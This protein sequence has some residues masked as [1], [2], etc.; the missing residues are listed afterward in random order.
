MVRIQNVDWEVGIKEVAD[1]SVDLLLTDPP[2]GMEYQSNRRKEKHK[3]IQNDNNLDWLVGW[4]DELKRVMKDE[5]H[6]YIFCSW[7]NVEVFKYIVG[8]QFNVKNILIWE[9]NN[10][11]SGDLLG[12]YAPKYEMV[13]FC[14]NGQKKLKGGRDSN[15]LKADKTAND[16]HPTE[17][18]INL[19]SYLINKSTN[20][21]DLVLDT[22]GGSCVTA[23]ASKQLQRNCICFEIEE[24]YCKNAQTRLSA[25]D[26]LL[27]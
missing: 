26:G 25:T 12:D 22:F 10:H 27:F 23:I 6:L 2:Y 7:H 18:P 16:N 24:S 9:K 1:K 17:K 13:L 3:S 15:I 21:G 4:V 20:I 5:A 8:K 11:G 14:S 19:I